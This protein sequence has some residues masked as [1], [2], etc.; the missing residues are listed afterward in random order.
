M[1]QSPEQRH[2]REKPDREV[3]ER[4]FQEGMSDY[5]LAELARLRIRYHNFPGANEIKRDLELLLQQW[6]LT[7]EALFE[8][9]RQIHSYRTI[10]R[11][12]ETDQE[13]WS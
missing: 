7:E 3:V 13:D 6:G 12:R 1:S 10:Y 2:P 9:T 5:N 11:K 8:K 4:L